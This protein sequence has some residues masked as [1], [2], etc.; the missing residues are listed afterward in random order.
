[1]VV[2]ILGGLEDETDKNHVVCGS[3][4]SDCPI[5][6]DSG[7]KYGCPMDVYCIWNIDDYRDCNFS[8]K[9]VA[10]PL[11]GACGCVGGSK[12]GC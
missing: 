5:Y 3:C 11:I 6:N 12:N 1:M 2:N 4:Y 10:T 8:N 9:S 7:P